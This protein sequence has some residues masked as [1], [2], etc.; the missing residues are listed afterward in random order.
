MKNGSKL[1]IILENIHSHINEE[2]KTDQRPLII[3]V[4]A[5]LLKADRINSYILSFKNEI[6]TTIKNQNSY[7]SKIYKYV[8]KYATQLNIADKVSFK[9][10]FIFI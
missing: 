2:F 9:D 5:I 10:D 7:I 6:N 4:D 3:N 8:L 1:N